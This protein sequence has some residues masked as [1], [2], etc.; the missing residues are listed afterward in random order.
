[1]GKGKMVA[2]KK[3][4][5][6]DISNMSDA[7]L[8]QIMASGQAGN[9]LR[10]MQEGNRF[11]QGEMQEAANNMDVDQLNQAFGSD[12]TIQKLRQVMSDPMQMMKMEKQNLVNSLCGFK[13]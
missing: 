4:M 6:G 13:L 1:M 3:K 10:S 9:I 7:E 11:N 5:G 12:A 8:R 2:S